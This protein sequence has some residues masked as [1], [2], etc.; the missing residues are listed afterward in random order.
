MNNHTCMESYHNSPMAI[1]YVNHA[2]VV[3]S[4]KETSFSC[5]CHL[6]MEHT[7]MQA[8]ATQKMHTL[9]ATQ[10]RNN[11]ERKEEEKDIQKRHCSYYVVSLQKLKLKLKGEL[12]SNITQSNLHIQLTGCD[13]KNTPNQN[14]MLLHH[15]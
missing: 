4:N 1:F 7:L 5:V 13:F 3:M 14:N 12:K 15:T 8:R 6:H 11:E 9:L 10:A 2:S